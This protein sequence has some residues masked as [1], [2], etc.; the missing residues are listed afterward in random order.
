MVYQNKPL[1]ENDIREIIRE[2]AFI[3]QN[4]SL[5]SAACLRDG[6]FRLLESTGTLI[7][8]PFERENLWGIY[9]YKDEKNFYIINSGTELEKQVFAAAH[10]L[11][12]SLEIAKV[13]Y[14]ALTP[15]LMME[16]TNNS[17]YGVKIL[18]ADKI[19]NRFAAEL[20]VGEKA[21]KEEFSNM[22]GHY[23]PMVKCVLLSDKFLVPYR[24]VARRLNETG[25]I[26]SKELKDLLDVD[27]SELKLTAERYECCIRNYE[28]SNIKQL[29][30][31]VNK[32]LTM[33]ENDL[34]TYD[35]L[36]NKLELIGKTPEDYDIQ[37]Y[38]L[39]LS[40]FI[41]RAS[42][43]TETEYGADE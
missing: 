22:P 42:E 21:L 35:D 39:D 11:A 6:V 20:L 30:G 12:H 13:T 5:D 33:Y 16:Y 31:Y 29:G 8:Y 25:L 26:T 34:Y 7:F 1:G 27:E 3:R 14:E 18:K 40:E 9:I 4:N 10:E 24:A 36:K 32:A 17:Q 43:D 37:F 15:E 23:N 28:I 19:A 38:D 2:V 41:L